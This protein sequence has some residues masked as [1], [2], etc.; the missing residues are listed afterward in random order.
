MYDRLEKDLGK[1]RKQG[2]DRAFNRITKEELVV[3]GAYEKAEGNKRSAD[4][5]KKQGDM[6]AHHL[7]MADHHDNM[8]EW[9]AS[10]G[11]HGEADR[12]AEKSEQHHEKAMSLKEDVALEESMAD[13]WKKVQS[14]DKGSVLQGKEGARKRLAYLQAVHAHHKKYG[15]D[16]KKVK[17][18][19]EGINR[20]R[21]AEE[22]KLKDAC[23][24]GYEAIGMKE[25]D[26]KKVPNCVPVKEEAKV[27]PV[28]GEE[29]CTCNKDEAQLGAH[30][31]K[32][33]DPF[34]AEEV[35]TVDLSDYETDYDNNVGTEN[36]ISDEELLS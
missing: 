5:A 1:K 18:E 11:R 2:M 10:K 32:G 27:C 13:S 6:F 12:H 31:A 36:E 15:N 7:H 21:L 24:T 3:E 14:M 28:C 8:A 29:E 20:S 26:G 9:H 4:A 22:D 34:V 30:N 23:W 33:F 17:K 35:E 19:I 25:K 16:T